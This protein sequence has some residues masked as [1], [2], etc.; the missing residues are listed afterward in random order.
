[1]A[2]KLTE[3]LTTRRL[4]ITLTEAFFSFLHIFIFI[5]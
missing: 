3:I 4:M 5:P 1:M 2:K